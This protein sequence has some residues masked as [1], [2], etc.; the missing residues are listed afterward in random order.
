MPASVSSSRLKTF[1]AWAHCLP[2]A[3]T[4]RR[5]MDLGQSQD[6]SAV[7]DNEGV[8]AILPKSHTHPSTGCMCGISPKSPLCISSLNHRMNGEEA[9]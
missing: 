8:V 4:H 3:M 2:L 6:T 7:G 5:L 1:V 9:P